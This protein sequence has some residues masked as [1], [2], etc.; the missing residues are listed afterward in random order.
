VRFEIPHNVRH[1]S[2]Q[3]PQW[4]G[5]V[6]YTQ[7]NPPVILKSKEPYLASY[8]LKPDLLNQHLSC[9]R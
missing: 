1:V 7:L 3:K 2:P 5:S 8:V 4:L 6:V 9:S